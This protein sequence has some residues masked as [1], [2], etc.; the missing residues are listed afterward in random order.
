[1]GTPAGPVPQLYRGVYSI[2]RFEVD[3]VAFVDFRL[4][5]AEQAKKN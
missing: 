1:M 5:T 3:R 4:R 2:A